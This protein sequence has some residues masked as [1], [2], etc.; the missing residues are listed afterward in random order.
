MLALIFTSI[1]FKI[2][3]GLLNHVIFYIIKY[4]YILRQNQWKSSIKLRV[5]LILAGK[6]IIS[7]SCKIVKASNAETHR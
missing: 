3:W 2:Y 4:N 5:E 6:Q 7:N 1:F